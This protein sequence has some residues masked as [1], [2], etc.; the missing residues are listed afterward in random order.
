MAEFDALEVVIKAKDEATATLEKTK[1]AFNDV[2]TSAEQAAKTTQQNA[3]S[4]QNVA[5]GVFAG[6]AALDAAKAAF[7]FLKN[8][9]TAAIKEASEYQRV[10][11]QLSAALKS[12]GNVVGFT[13]D[14]ITQYA[15]KL[16][17]LTAIDDDAI[18]SAQAMLVTFTNLKDEAF[19]GATQAVLD[20]ATAMNG[21]GIPSMEQLRGAALQIGKALNN[22]LEGLTALTRAGVTFTEQQKKQIETMIKAGNVA[23]A[24]KVALDELAK[25]FGGSAAAAAETFEGRMARL[26]NSLGDVKKIIGQ[27]L[28][29]TLSVF[30][31]TVADSSGKI[32]VN[33]TDLK[34]WQLGIYQAAVIL[35]GLIGVTVN[36]IKT[37]YELGKV[38]FYTG[39]TIVAIFQDIGGVIAN[40]AGKFSMLGKIFG[41]VIM[42]IKS[43]LQSDFAQAIKTLSGDALTAVGNASAQVAKK[44]ASSDFVKDNFSN[45]TKSFNELTEAMGS[46]SQ[47]VVNV[48]D[49]MEKAIEEA[50][51]HTKF[52]AVIDGMNKAK[53][54]ANTLGGDMGQAV[55]NAAGKTAEARNKIKEEFTKLADDYKE[56]SSRAAEELTKLE[57]AH[58]EATTNI[59]GQ[60]DELK[61][62]L[63]E[64]NEEYKKSM[65]EINKTEAESVVAQEEKIK[66]LQKNLAEAQKSQGENPNESGAKRVAEL[67]AALNAEQTAYKAYIDSRKGL[68]NELTEA[69]RRAALTDF[70]RTI[71]D[72]NAKRTQA[73][74][75]HNQKM[76]QINAE[77]AEQ[78][79][80]MARERIVFEAKRAEY[81]ATQEAFTK[82]HNDYVAKIKGMQTVTQASVDVMKA[83][84]AEIKNAVSQIESARNEA[85]LQALANA[86]VQTPGQAA[87]AAGAATGPATININFGGVNITSEA[88]MEKLTNDLVRKLQLAKLGTTQ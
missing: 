86:T 10:D 5:K 48:F 45:T 12:T 67:Q 57:T 43:A 38:L 69:R 30:A 37:A 75:E 33:E 36:M 88:D 72:I 26:Q 17:G 81:L 50:K 56:G 42:G 73:E 58:A 44:I 79:A 46:F 14:Q 52:D 71:E 77:I 27:A 47:S 25:E 76:E 15:E 54:A 19:N 51:N 68:E 32:N 61:A 40:T 74:T 23:G 63:K 18:K 70:Q 78:E 55:I 22:P 80:T 59:K 49:P 9:V 6:T 34:K 11:A 2:K 29:P 8:E 53:N 31:D 16:S 85:G 41:V 3:A 1:T 7:G 64:L 13:K 83:K 4:W 62:S 35:K 28:L 66:D 84:L 39:K 21:G 60:I 82:F 24:Q 65:G 20:M 87:A